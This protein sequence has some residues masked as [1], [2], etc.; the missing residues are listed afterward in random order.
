MASYRLTIIFTAAD[1]QSVNAAGMKVAVVKGPHPSAM[2]TA[3]LWLQFAPFETNVLTWTDSYGLYASP[4]PVQAETPITGSSTL[5]PAD[6]GTVYPFAN[7]VFGTPEGSIDPSF[8]ASH[9]QSGRTLTFGLLQPA[10]VNGATIPP[11]PV[12]AVTSF[13]QTVASFVPTATVSVFLHKEVDLGTVVSI[14]ESS[15][16]TVDMATSP[17]QTIYYDGT[18]FT[19]QPPTP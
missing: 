14:T 6:S 13:D 7:D 9:N 1:T 15:A 12:N 2:D 18:S 4:D 8:Y 17:T 19:T 16:L 10:V 11:T 5:Y 3:P